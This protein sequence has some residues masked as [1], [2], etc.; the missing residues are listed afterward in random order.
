MK[1]E[2]NIP[3]GLLFEET[4]PQP[5]D[6]VVPQYD[7]AADISYVEGP[8]GNRIPYVEIRSAIGTQ[9]ETK[10]Q[11]EPTD[12]DPGDDR[13][14]FVATGASTFAE[15]RVESTDTNFEDDNARSFGRLGTDTVTRISGEPTDTDPGDGQRYCNTWGF[16]MGTETVT[17]EAKESTDKD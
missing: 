1:R 9:T 13:T 7:E 12:T 14:S 3:F 17:K 10:A 8:A 11:G 15:V 16:M 2:T 4:A 6:L 5:Q